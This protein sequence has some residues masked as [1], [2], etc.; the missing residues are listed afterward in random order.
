MTVTPWSDA[1]KALVG[2]AF[3]NPAMRSEAEKADLER[4]KVDI[5]RKQYQLDE[6]LNPAKIRQAEAAA[7]YNNAQSKSEAVKM[8]MDQLKLDNQRRFLEGGN[9][10]TTPSMAPMPQFN[11][12]NVGPQG[13]GNNPAM[14]LPYD[15]IKPLDALPRIPAITDQQFD[16]F[17][18]EPLPIGTPYNPTT[19]P[20][21]P[22]MADPFDELIAELTGAAPEAMPPQPVPIAPM[23]QG[24][25][26]PQDMTEMLTPEIRAM[27]AGGYL[28]GQSI[29]DYL[30]AQEGFKANQGVTDPNKRIL[31]AA[32]GRGTFAS[33]DQVTAQ[34][35]GSTLP[36]GELS[37]I[38][39]DNMGTS[40]IKNFRESKKNPDFAAF[41]AT[42]N[43]GQ[44]IE[45]NTNGTIKR[46]GKGTGGKGKGLTEQQSKVALNSAVMAP[47]VAALTQA[48]NGGK[49]SSAS[50]LAV[51]AMFGDDPFITD[52]AQRANLINEDDQMLNAAV[53]GVMN[54]LYLQTGASRTENEDKRGYVELT[55]LASDSAEARNFKKAQLEQKARSII[56]QAPSP[57]MQ[58]ELL[59][60]VEG[61]WT[62]QI[63]GSTNQIGEAPVQ[64]QSDDEYEAL[65][66]GATFIAPDGTTRTKP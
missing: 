64:I 40:D 52:M 44:E 13:Q 24:S 56:R 43:A 66:S 55:P 22:N 47:G 29:G 26:G 48:Y 27:I 53:N 49:A 23:G 4:Q 10:N 5:Q 25:A 1:A 18:V 9:Q 34:A 11:P 12:Y 21:P 65:P 58:Q 57:E 59:K 63:P 60:A 46:I 54:F 51:R 6:A 28:P 41:L 8:M 42:Q 31:N 61:I 36:T 37:Q 33:P 45:F 38:G 2:V 30:L 16:E 19:M 3:G 35:M 15:Q 32:A 17:P 7:R 20:N 62:S 14:V 50:N 39:V